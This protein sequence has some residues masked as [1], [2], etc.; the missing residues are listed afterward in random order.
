MNVDDALKGRVFYRSEALAGIDE[1]DPDNERFPVSSLDE[2]NL[3]SSEVDHRWAK[4]HKPVLDIDFPAWL[5]PSSTE[6]H[7][8][9]YLDKEMSWDQYK[10][11]L[12]ALADV[13]ILQEGYVN[14][15]IERKATH[16]RLPWIK[17]HTVEGEPF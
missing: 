7:F 8:H 12:N 1:Y 10:K 15:S 9:L 6:G 16:V 11:L 17:K 4:D 14:V 3:V 13:G 5:V 2:A